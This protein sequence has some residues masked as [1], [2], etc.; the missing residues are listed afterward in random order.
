MYDAPSLLSGVPPIFHTTAP[1]TSRANE[2]AVDKVVARVEPLPWVQSVTSPFSAAGVHQIAPPSKGNIAFAQVQFTTDTAD[3]PVPAIKNVIRT[4]Q[5]AAHQ[6]FQV[7]L[8]GA[9]ISA[10]ATAAPGPAKAP[11]DHPIDVLA[12]ASTSMPYQSAGMTPKIVS[13]NDTISFLDV[14]YCDTIF[15]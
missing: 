11:V 14:S 12:A 13:P 7:E 4:A 6:G 1:V 10:A 15:P 5:A 2:A 9:P 3:I 8:G